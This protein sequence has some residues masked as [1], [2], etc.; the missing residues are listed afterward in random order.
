[1]S[2]LIVRVALSGL[3]V[4]LGW[5]WILNS[6]AVEPGSTLAVKSPLDEVTSSF[7]TLTPLAVFA[8]IVF[9]CEGSFACQ[10]TK[11]GWSS[12]AWDVRFEGQHS[13]RG[14]RVVGFHGDRFHL[15]TGAIADIEGGRDLAFFAG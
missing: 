14:F 13:L 8:M 11:V 7:L 10:K 1:M 4:S 15:H 5:I 9:A 3:V 2:G 6:P 12:T